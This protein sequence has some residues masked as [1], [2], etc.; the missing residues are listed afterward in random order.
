MPP[1]PSAPHTK[2]DDVSQAKRTRHVIVANHDQINSVGELVL[3]ALKH[4][5]HFTPDVVARLRP[6][7]G[8]PGREGRTS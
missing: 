8:R 3:N 5:I 1:T 4:E 7:G 6:Q 2:S